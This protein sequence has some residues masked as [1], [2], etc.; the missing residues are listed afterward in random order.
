[1]QGWERAI[2]ILLVQRTKPQNTNLLKEERN[3]KAVEDKRWASILGQLKVLTGLL[4][5]ASPTPSNT[6]SARS[7]HRDTERRI[8]DLTY[9]E[10]PQRGDV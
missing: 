2:H 1:M 5:P 6:G 9:G 7:F 8:K 10:V 4:K 3:G